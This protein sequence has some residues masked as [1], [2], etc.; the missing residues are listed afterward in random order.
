MKIYIYT[1][2]IALTFQVAIF[3]YNVNVDPQREDTFLQQEQTKD[4]QFNEDKDLQQEQTHDIQF[5]EDKYL[6]REQTRDI[7]FEEDKDFKQERELG[8]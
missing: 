8:R 2:F 1:S 5:E 4:I 3:A 7:Q 6:Q